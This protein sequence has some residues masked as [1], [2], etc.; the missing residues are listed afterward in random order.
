[1]QK[2]ERPDSDL[3]KQ[4]ERRLQEEALSRTSTLLFVWAAANAVYGFVSLDL[5]HVVYKDLT[6]WDN[7][8]P[9]LVVSF[10]CV[11]IALWYQKKTQFVVPKIYLTCL[12]LPSLLVTASMIHA[13]PAMWRGHY[14]FYLY[15]HATNIFA[16]M[17]G[18]ALISGSPRLVALQGASFI[19]IYFGPLIYL[20]HQNKPLLLELI[21]SDAVLASFVMYLGQIKVH[22]LRYRVALNEIK[23]WKKA[24]S[25]LGQNLATAIAETRDMTLQDYTQAGLIMSTDIRG[26]TRLTKEAPLA[27]KAFMSEYHSVITQTV[28]KRGA[29]LHKTAGDGLLISF[30]VMEKR[31][32]LSDIPGIE[33]DVA[34]AELNQKREFIRAAHAVF[35]EISTHLIGLKVKYQIDLPLSLGAG[36]SFG[37][38]EIVVR[39]DERYRQELDIDGEAIILATRLEGYSKRIAGENDV[40]PASFFVVAPDLGELVMEELQLNLCITDTKTTQVRDFPDLKHV[41]YRKLKPAATSR[42]RRAS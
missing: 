15:F 13:W 2:P 21:L 3:R 10:F 24:S 19:I 34:L 7:V 23:R 4:V 30:G 5:F 36:C 31:Q 42:V 41:F 35:E 17:S 16:M 1:M 25:F 29:Y 9:R 6:L 26:Y 37:P 11:M 20:L 40:N 33:H 28:S 27:V 22:E 32:D 8:W 38:I 18:I 39:G 14:D 12:I